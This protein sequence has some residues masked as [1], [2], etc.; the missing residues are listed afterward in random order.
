MGRWG[1]TCSSWSPKQPCGPSG[2]MRE[3]TQGARLAT[4]RLCD[5]EGV[6]LRPRGGGCAGGKGVLGVSPG[7]CVRHRPP[8]PSGSGAL[9]GGAL[10]SVWPTSHDAGGDHVS[11]HVMVRC[12]SRHL[13]CWLPGRSRAGFPRARARGGVLGTRRGSGG[14]G[15]SC[16]DHRAGQL[17]VTTGGE[18]GVVGK[19]WAGSLTAP[20]PGCLSAPGVC[21]ALRQ[22]HLRRQGPAARRWHG[23]RA[24]VRTPPHRNGVPTW[25][26]KAC[27]ASPL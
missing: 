26:P 1:H 19:A 18:P 2:Q 8:E 25:G 24:G 4:P 12:C 13:P 16:H 23:L 15:A 20:G 14:K 11:P 3:Q 22:L 17:E 5:L 27:L 21:S 7:P 9:H 10:A 6:R